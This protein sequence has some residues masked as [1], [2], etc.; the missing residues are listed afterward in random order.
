[1]RYK[2]LF[3][4]LVLFSC[5]KQTRP[6]KPDDLLSKQE[7]SN[8]LY[9]M[10]IINSAK[11]SSMKTLQEN[12]VD[13]DRYVLEKYNIDSTRFVNS[14]TYYAY[15]FEDYREIL[16][17]IEERIKK[18]Q[19]EYQDLLEEEKIASKKRIDSLKKKKPKDKK[20]KRSKD[21]IL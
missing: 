11:G 7:M 13:P 16:I 18:E 5:E 14:N 8:I 19:E 1:M 12:G 9:D 6:D 10:I 20:T 21:S 3:L 2:L 15:D 4:V 17:S